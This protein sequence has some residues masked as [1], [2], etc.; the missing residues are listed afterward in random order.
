MSGR[1]TDHGQGSCFFLGQPRCQSQTPMEIHMSRSITI[2]T[3]SATRELCAHISTHSDFAP[4][5]VAGAGS[6][7]EPLMSQKLNL[8]ME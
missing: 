6:S 3:V 1:G 5:R 2:W 4:S 8:V 7:G